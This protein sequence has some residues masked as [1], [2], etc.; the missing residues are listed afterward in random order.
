MESF[1]FRLYFSY[2]CLLLLVFVSIFVGALRKTHATEIYMVWYVFSF[3]FVLFFALYALFFAY[4][5]NPASHQTEIKSSFGESE[6]AFFQTVFNYLTDFKG[7]VK[8]VLAV[9]GLVVVP[10]LLTYLLSGLS[11]SAS[12]PVFVSQITKVAI[13]SLVKFLA[14]FSGLLAAIAVWGWFQPWPSLGTG[15]GGEMD[16]VTTELMEI[17]FPLLAAFFLAWSHDASRRVLGFLYQQTAFS[18]FRLVHEFFTR[19]SQAVEKP[20]GRS[21]RKERSRRAAH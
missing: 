18:R 14:A 15:I 17:F 5:V 11:G 20:I 21:A 19:H 16:T 4:A 3:V 9:V 2:P 1:F 12:P 13:W 6:A 10:Q 7:E 8:M